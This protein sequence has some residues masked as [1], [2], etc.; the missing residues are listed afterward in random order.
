MKIFKKIIGKAFGYQYFPQADIFVPFRV[1]NSDKFKE[2]L[3]SRIR[4]Y[5]FGINLI[6]K[7]GIEELCVLSCCQ[8]YLYRIFHTH[9]T[10]RQS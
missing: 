3:H 1:L 9:S 2:Q 6:G 4:S 8:S 10:Y 7:E 5:E